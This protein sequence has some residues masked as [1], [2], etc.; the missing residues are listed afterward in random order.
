MQG[1][2]LGAEE[3]PTCKGLWAAWVFR[4]LARVRV[5]WSEESKLRVKDAETERV[6]LENQ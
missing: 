5:F 2:G 4:A 3:R 6:S 1:R